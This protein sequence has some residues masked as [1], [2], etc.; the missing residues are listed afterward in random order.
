MK[1]GFSLIFV[2]ILIS[3]MGLLASY[4]LTI[5][6]T[7]TIAS[8]SVALADEAFYIA[9][10]GLQWVLEKEFFNPAAPLASFLDANAYSTPVSLGDG[11]FTVQ[12]DNAAETAID[13]I[14]TGAI[15]RGGQTYT[16]EVKLHLEGT[17][18]ASSGESSLPED[19]VQYVGGEINIFNL[20]GDNSIEGDLYG[21]D[22]TVPEGVVDGETNETGEENPPAVPTFDFDMYKQRIQDLDNGSNIRYIEGNLTISGS[23]T[24]GIN[25][26][27]DGILYYVTGDVDVKKNTVVIYGTIITEGAI[28]AYNCSLAWIAVDFDIDPD[29]PGYE[30][31]PVMASQEA[32]HFNNVEPLTLQGFIWCGSD[33][34]MNNLEDVGMTGGII[35]VGSVDIH[36]VTDFSFVSDNDLLFPLEGEDEGGEGGGGSGGSAVSGTGLTAWSWSE[37]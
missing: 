4:V 22:I 19:V 35:A 8:G 36:N 25:N 14:V 10:A 20:S 23:T 31:M 16:R 21:T 12:Y 5:N 2:I 6:N 29:K 32:I 15:T 37:Q 3:L 11:S 33:V 7:S 30:K 24:R 13:I 27:G 1:K 26:P 28:H 18:S 17:M 9:D 34:Q